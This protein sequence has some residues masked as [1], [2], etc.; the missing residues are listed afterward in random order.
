MAIAPPAPEA[1]AAATVVTPSREA[2]DPAAEQGEAPGRAGTPAWLDVR[3]VGKSYGRQAVLE[4]VHLGIAEGEFVALLG[5]S[6]CGKTT[7]LRILCGIETATSGSVH[8][9]GRDI[10]VDPPSERR[11]GVVFQSYALFP[12]LSVADNVSY[13]L[14]GMDATHRRRRVINLLEMVDLAGHIDKLPAQLSG[15]QQQRVA[16]ARALAPSPR[17]LLLD[18]P[19]SAL[20]AQ[21]RAHLRG[22]IVAICRKLKVTTVMVTHDQDEALSMADRVVL[23]H[24]GRIEQVDAPQAMYAQPCTMFA[25]EFLGRMNLWPGQRVDGGGVKVGRAQLTTLHLD[26]PVGQAVRVGIRPEL[27]TWGY[28][29]RPGSPTLAPRGNTLLARVTWTSFHGSHY[30]L[31]AE[32]A[33][34]GHEVLLRLPTPVGPVLMLRPGVALRLTLPIE[35]LAV[36]PDAMQP[37]APVTNA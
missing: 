11:F 19:L 23:M 28:D 10:T 2:A 34:L 1:V 16:L 26:G 31:G 21:V 12:N 15:G 25:A 8:L 35:A 7:L 36:L 30:D 33:D 6:G 22:E 14:R 32:C 3:G 29:P 9:A 27:I 13:G 17:L 18:E 5:P 4:D 24:R 20:D 37:T